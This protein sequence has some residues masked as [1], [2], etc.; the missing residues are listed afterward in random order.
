ML[1]KRCS[2]LCQNNAPWLLTNVN[3]GEIMC[4][5]NI[6]YCTNIWEIGHFFTKTAFKRFSPFCFL[7]L[8]NS[9][10]VS[11][12]TFIC[13]GH[14]YELHLFDTLMHSYIL[15]CVHRRTYIP[16]LSLLPPARKRDTSGVLDRERQ[17][18]MKTVWVGRICRT[19]PHSKPA[20]TISRLK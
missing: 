17:V 10:L 9:K 2:A 7:V 11:M 19:C 12:V 8:K 16:S 18:E 20:P 15:L 13:F 1:I 3:T 6:L 4:P 14:N 5:E